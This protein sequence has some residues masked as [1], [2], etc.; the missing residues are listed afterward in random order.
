MTQTTSEQ[1]KELAAEQ[2]AQFIKM[3]RNSSEKKP[4]DDKSDALRKKLAELLDKI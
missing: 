2:D 4:S 3:L 1:S